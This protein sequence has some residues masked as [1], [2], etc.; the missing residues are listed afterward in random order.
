[1]PLITVYSI[2]HR[3]VR[4]WIAEPGFEKKN[5]ETSTLSYKRTKIHGVKIIGDQRQIDQ[6]ISIRKI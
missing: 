2:Q 6:L 5:S 4:C 1:M 3:S